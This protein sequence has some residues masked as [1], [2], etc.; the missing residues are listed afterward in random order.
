[1]SK[2]Q[3]THTIITKNMSSSSNNQNKNSKARKRTPKKKN[4]VIGPS[5]SIGI[6][7][8]KRLTSQ[9]PITRTIKN[10]ICVKHIEMIGPVAKTAS[11]GGYP[12]GQDL[13]QAYRLR[14]NPASGNTFAWLSSIAPNFEFYKFRNLRFYY[15]TR[16]PTT[17][18]GSIII[19][20]DYD[21]ADGQVPVSEKLLFNNKGTVD[22]AVYKHLS[23]NL[24]PESMNRLYKSHVNMSD[25][26]FA[27]TTQDIKTI[28]A[29]QVYVCID[30]A[31]ATAFRFGKLFVQY[32]VELTEPQAPTEPPNKGGFS[33]NISIDGASLSTK[34]FPAA[35]SN[36]AYKADASI[37]ESMAN[38]PGITSYP[39]ATIGRFVKDFQG[40]AVTRTNGTGLSLANPVKYYLGSDPNS[41]AGT[42]DDVVINNIGAIIDA[43]A[44]NTVLQ[45][46]F[47]AVA[48]QYLKMKNP[49]YT[50]LNANYLDVGGIS[51]A[52]II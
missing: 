2:K 20:P 8:S 24:S 13:Y 48:G 36:A 52:N 47:N 41:A 11:Q 6:A 23:C 26:R 15:E 32:E 1:M 39:S 50:L 31:D 42:G 29:A 27:T 19:S 30:S 34:P 14:V 16:S 38:L 37:I 33:N 9:K 43:A 46:T 45:T 3:S 10:G 12:D 44:T 35:M 7:T 40:M 18:A 22:D 51:V 4:Q 28:D 5:F 17:T 49:A 25:T 21:A